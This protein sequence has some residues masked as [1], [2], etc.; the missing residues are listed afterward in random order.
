MKYRNKIRYGLHSAV[1]FS[2]SCKQG[3]RAKRIV[4]IL[5]ISYGE[6][7]KM[8]AEKRERVWWN[9]EYLELNERIF[10]KGY[11]TVNSWFSK[12]R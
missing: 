11:K 2:F 5:T 1:F 7:L 3:K 8:E 12:K 9:I 4:T 6:A 10:W